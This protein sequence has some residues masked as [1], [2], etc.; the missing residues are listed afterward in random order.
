MST[1]RRHLAPPAFLAVLTLIAV[2]AGAT[3]V[4]PQ[5]PGSYEEAIRTWRAQREA[6]LRADDGWLTLVGLHW[7]GQGPNT[8]GSA[9]GSAVRLPASAPAKLGTI[10]FD[11]AAA[12]FTPA[13]GVEVRI[14]G[15]P[16][17]AMRL[18][19]QPGDYETVTTGTVSFFIIQRGTR[20]GV[21]VRDA[22]SPERLAFAGV[23]WYPVREAYRIRARYVAHDT[24]ASIMIPNV[25]GDLTAWTSPG[26]VSFTM[27]GREVRLHPVLEG[28]NAREL[29]FIF[30][31]GT[32][33]NDTYPGGRFLYADLP[34]DGE[35]LLDFNKAISPPC[36]YTQYATCPLPPKENAL[37][38]RIE[39][40]ELNPHGPH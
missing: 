30:R 25:L 40:G 3:L 32:T 36:A 35:V 21:R 37:T 1:T 8:V 5:S 10:D 13:P 11:G 23:R 4:S 18:R 22:A 27:D 34:P 6:E 17:R 19:P 16:A 2:F 33:G 39:A 38:V 29:F 9:E 31:D 28:E 26:Y 12:A 7:L 14:N 15:A 24:P 20:F